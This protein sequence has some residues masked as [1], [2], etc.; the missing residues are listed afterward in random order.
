MI[1][2]RKLASKRA[3]RKLIRSAREAF[4]IGEETNHESISWREFLFD[5]ELEQGEKNSKEM[6]AWWNRV[7]KAVVRAI[8]ETE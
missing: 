7:T 3:V 6:D 2:K 1:D 4:A 5:D 8:K